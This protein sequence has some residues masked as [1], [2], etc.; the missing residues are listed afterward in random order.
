MVQVVHAKM[1]ALATLTISEVQ[2][3]SQ[4]SRQ[5]G[6]M[7]LMTGCTQGQISRCTHVVIS[8]CQVTNKD[9]SLHR[10]RRSGIRP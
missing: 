6:C 2:Q 8:V 9:H 10:N 1:K 7:P 3:V 4:N 5:H